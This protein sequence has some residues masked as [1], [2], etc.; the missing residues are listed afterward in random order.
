[1]VCAVH[2]RVWP[3]DAH[4]AGPNVLCYTGHHVL[5]MCPAS[6]VA[7]GTYILPAA[8]VT[9]PIMGLQIKVDSYDSM[10]VAMLLC[11]HASV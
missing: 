7:G 8:A 4:P 10:A 1:L 6:F 9:S 3:V 2:R 5:V 11:V